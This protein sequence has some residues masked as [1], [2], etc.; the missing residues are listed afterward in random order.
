MS[1]DE[2]WDRLKTVADPEIPNL[3]IVDLGMV[4]RVEIDQGHVKVDL[5][6]TFVG[7][8]ALHWIEQKVEEALAPYPTTVKFVYR[9]PWTTERLTA[10]GRERLLEW[11]VAPPHHQPGPVTCPLCG[12]QKTHLNS[13]FGPSLC[14]AIYYCD[15][16]QQP[17]E[18]M[19][20]I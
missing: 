14:R 10:R 11:G 6:P 17:F 4:D 15:E 1:T 3:S 18:A 9:T 12:S 20:A 8:P 7:C 16:C 19:K 13:A 5:M 2:I